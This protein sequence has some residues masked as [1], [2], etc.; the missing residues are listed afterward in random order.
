MLTSRRSFL[1]GLAASLVAAPAVVR[2]AS[3][4]PVR[5]IIQPIESLP[6]DLAYLDLLR[7]RMNDVYRLTHQAM[8]RN[9][10]GDPDLV[11]PAPPPLKELGLTLTIQGQKFRV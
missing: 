8:T 4:M 10:F 5:G 1:T 3:L 2:A 6:I 11:V 7:Q 9:L